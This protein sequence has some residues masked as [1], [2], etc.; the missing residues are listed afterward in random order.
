MSIKVSAR[1]VQELL[2]GRLSHDHFSHPGAGSDKNIFD[3]FLKSG[4]TISSVRLEP[5]GI[6]DDDDCLIFEFAQ[7]PAASEFQAK[8]NTEIV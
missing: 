7:D 4:L 6:D 8:A 3:H 1:A 2:A 5:G